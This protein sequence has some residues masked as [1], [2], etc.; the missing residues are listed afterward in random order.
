MASWASPSCFINCGSCCSSS[1]N[2]TTSRFSTSSISRSVFSAHSLIHTKD[3]DKAWLLRAKFEKFQSESSQDGLEELTAQE[4]QDN[5]DDR[6]T[7][8]HFWVSRFCF[9]LIINFSF[10]FFGTNFRCCFIKFHDLSLQLSLISVTKYIKLLF[11]TFEV[12]GSRI[13]LL[14]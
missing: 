2:S 8:L 3:K 6:Y 4:V 14:L 13:H 7:L 9:L 11:C 12:F 1:P 5:E 10:F